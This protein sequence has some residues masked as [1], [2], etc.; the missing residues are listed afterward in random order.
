MSENQLSVAELSQELAKEKKKSATLAKENHALRERIVNMQAEAEMEEEA[1][2][3]ALT[4]RLNDLK[5]EKENLVVTVE[6][7]E[8]HISN[9]LQRKLSEVQKEKVDLEDKLEKEQEYVTNRLARQIEGLVAEKKGLEQK[10]F[11]LES[12]VKKQSKDKIDLENLLEQEQEMV[13]NLLQKQLDS[14]M[15][16]KKALESQVR[17]DHVMLETL[18]KEKTALMAKLKSEHA[19]AERLDESLKA[20]SRENASRTKKIIRD[21]EGWE[22]RVQG[23]ME[24]FGATS[25]NNEDASVV[26]RMAKEIAVL[27]GRESALLA[28]CSDHEAKSENLYHDMVRL[29]GT[30]DHLLSS[31]ERELQRLRVALSGS[32]FKCSPEL[33]AAIAASHRY[34]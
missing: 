30:H 19:H 25:N 17:K 2:I 31:V 13:T 9:T 24:H 32:S 33:E 8:E 28:Q 6:Q 14:T 34:V 27:S 29:K 20:L 21:A 16:E 22:G 18:S 5:K 15:K 11:E 7:E 26:E 4:K 12:S 10:L 3:N 1:R 23:V